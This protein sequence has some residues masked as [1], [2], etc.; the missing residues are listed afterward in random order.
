METPKRHSRI[1][2][3]DV[4]RGFAV[5]GIVLLHNIEHFNFY[6]FPDTAGASPWL[7]FADRCVWDGLFFMFGGKAYAI[8]ALLF[9]FSFFIQNDNQRLR[10]ND[11]RLRFC[12]RLLLLFVIGNI[13]AMF[14]TAEVLVLFSLTGIVLVATCRLSTRWLVAIAAACMLQPI[15]L[16][17]IFRVVADPTYTP[18]TLPTS[19]LWAAT[20]AQQEAGTFLSTLKVNLREGQLVSLAWAWDNGRVFQTASLFILGMLIGR[21]GWFKREYLP[22]WG[23]VAIVSAAIF[24]P[25]TGIYNLLPRFIENPALATPLKLFLSSIYKAAFMSMTVSAILYLYYM[26]TMKSLLDKLIPYGKLS[27]TNYVTQSVMGAFIYYNWGLGMHKYLGITAS[28][29]VGAAM[30]LF[31][32]WLCRIWLKSHKH[33]PMEGVWK[34]LT[35]I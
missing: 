18:Y 7:A 34:R 21:Q 16:Y 11:F 31:Q 22:K 8:F 35:W 10:G 14:F 1:D 33:G 9:G 3:A 2:V 12:W 15:A 20:Y 32:L 13:N 5:M 26:T 25:F 30:F 4:L 19:D 24:F 28:V 29:C 27:M 6:S 23:L 17:N